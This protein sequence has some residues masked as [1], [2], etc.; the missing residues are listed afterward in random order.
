MIS[1]GES[2]KKTRDECV[3]NFAQLLGLK[4]MYPLQMD[5]LLHAKDKF[6]GYGSQPERWTDIDSSKVDDKR[7]RNVIK[8]M[9]EIQELSSQEQMKWLTKQKQETMKEAKSAGMIAKTQEW[10]HRWHRGN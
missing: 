2:H 7:L 1:G 10:E 6:F 4:D 3:D 9:Q 8:V 5:E